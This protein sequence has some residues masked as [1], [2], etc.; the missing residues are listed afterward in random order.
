[1]A[2]KDLRLASQRTIST[3]QLLEQAAHDHFLKE[4]PLMT[5]ETRRVSQ[6]LNCPCKGILY[7]TLATTAAAGR[8]LSQERKRK[9]EKMVIAA[10]TAVT[11]R[12]GDMENSKWDK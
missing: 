11:A 10:I 6:P 5:K 9:K 7:S 1:M 8:S 12:E 4:R 3:S 2:E